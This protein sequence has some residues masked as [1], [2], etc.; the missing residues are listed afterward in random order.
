V[1]R[2]LDRVRERV[3]GAMGKRWRTAAAA[4]LVP[5]A[6]ALSLQGAAVAAGVFLMSKHLLAL[7]VALSIGAITWLW[8]PTAEPRPIAAAGGDP[9]RPADALQPSRDGA[10]SADV[11]EAAVPGRTSL[12]ATAAAPGAAI[13]ITGRVVDARGQ[14]I[15]G[16][17]LR[18]TTGQAAQLL[19]ATDGAGVFALPQRPPAL[20]AVEPRYAVLRFTP[21][22]ATA[23]G[24]ELRFIVAP[25]VAVSGL[26]VDPARAPLS[27]VEVEVQI[28]PLL[29]YPEPLDDTVGAALPAASVDERG[30]FAVEG[31]AG[32]ATRLRFHRP[33]FAP[34]TLPVASADA[35][36]VVV[37]M[38]PLDGRAFVLAGR[39]LDPAGTAVPEALVGLG[40]RTAR[41]DAFGSFE[42]EFHADDVSPGGSPLWAA[43]T[44]MQTTV[45]GRLL[46]TELPDDARTV[47]R[48]LVL[49]G[50]ARSIAGV[51]LD[52]R[53]EPV[54]GA[55]VSLWRENQVIGALFA[56]DLA[57]GAVPPAR[58]Q[59][60]QPM[61]GVT[62]G[63]RGG[64]ELQ[65][66]SEG[67]YRLRVL[68]D[69]LLGTTSAP[70]AAGSQ[71]VVIR[72]PQDHLQTVR[73]VT[74]D[75]L[76]APVKGVIVWMSVCELAV[77]GGV[78]WL[79][80]QLVTSDA[81]GRFELDRVPRHE[82]VLLSVGGQEL[83]TTSWTLGEGLFDERETVE[84][85]GADEVRLVVERRC[86]FRVESSDLGH[87]TARFELRDARD[88]SVWI[89]Q[90]SAGGGSTSH[91]TLALVEGKTEMLAASER[92][93]ALV[94]FDASGQELA[95]MPLQLRPGEP[96]VVRL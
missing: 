93:I 41:S 12:A 48:E 91:E 31:L 36:G 19:A 59:R 37:T 57:N 90:F 86:H 70:I 56:H 92:A 69:E 88:E 60:P 78:Q 82:Q 25:A 7:A 24:Q 8:W 73:G 53:G 89:S 28:A 2:G 66:L 9:P 40:E 23:V 79:K 43:K 62:T 42:L 45:A 39:V 54:A 65:G 63:E 34:S 30:R 51:V 5:D 83:V 16:V 22:H 10:P 47:R 13:G 26:V 74:V 6:R 84:R 44:G 11:R 96:A 38:T 71:G 68:H 32:G 35:H 75:R 94:L 1:K 81:E 21:L 80:G 14:P 33:G 58:G 50:P 72:Y 77:E 4:L 85:T 3:E 20:P 46:V 29:E 61:S 87:R 27:G 52:A 64:F 15:G 55:A 76:G 49:A 17:R 18:S 95:R 67:E